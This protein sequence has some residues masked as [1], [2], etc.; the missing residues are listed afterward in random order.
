VQVD[1]HPEAQSELR[2][3]ALWHDQQRAGLGDELFA[4]V[5]STLE[6]MATA[7]QAFPIWP[8][9]PGSENPI[10][11]ALLHRFPYAL[12]FEIGANRVLVL[13]VAHAKRRPFYWLARRNLG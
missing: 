11:R 3:A 9:L 8:T 12:A 2:R 6:R 10:R 4:D 13:A 1:L 5:G 7:P